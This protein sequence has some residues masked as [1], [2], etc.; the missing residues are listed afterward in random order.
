MAH[1]DPATGRLCLHVVFDGAPR[2]GKTT[3]IRALARRHGLQV[4]TPEER[5]GRT[6]YFDWLDFEGGQIRGQAIHCRTI[7]VP[8]QDE[9]AA[10]RASILEAADVVIFVADTS[11]AQLAASRNHYAEL[12]TLLAMSH[13]PIPIVVQLNKRDADDALSFETA[14]RVFDGGSSHLLESVATAGDGI[15]ETF[16]IAVSEA[17]RA[18]HQYATPAGIP[19]GLAVQELDL[20]DPRSLLERLLSQ[21]PSTP[22]KDGL[23]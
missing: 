22:G 2:S 4:E 20:A 12:K 9:H 23:L 18:L 3:T 15:Q 7:A 6:L 10:R 16:A 13:R 19:S 5:D 1:I 17:V 21:T 11:A 8:G 14:R